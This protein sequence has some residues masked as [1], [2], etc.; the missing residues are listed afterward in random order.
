MSEQARRI[1][2][3]IVPI[4]VSDGKSAAKAGQMVE[5]LIRT[6]LKPDVH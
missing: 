4:V 5:A 2:L 1:N 3:G 6:I